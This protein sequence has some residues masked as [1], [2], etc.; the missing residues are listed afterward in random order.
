MRKAPKIIV[1][2]A[3]FGG[4]TRNRHNL[5]IYEIILI[6]ILSKSAFH[7]FQPVPFGLIEHSVLMFYFIRQKRIVY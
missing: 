6:E 5:E 3:L 1:L 7:I 2:N 4:A